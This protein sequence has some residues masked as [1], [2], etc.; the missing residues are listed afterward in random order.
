[1]V[2]NHFIRWP[3]PFGGIPEVPRSVSDK[4]RVREMDSS[5]SR[6]VHREEIRRREGRSLKVELQQNSRHI[7]AEG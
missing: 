4:D 2:V 7:P 5:I 3:L 1:M 6:L